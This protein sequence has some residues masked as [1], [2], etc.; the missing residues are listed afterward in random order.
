VIAQ[1]VL[2]LGY[3]LDNWDTIPGMFRP[4]LG[5]TQPPIQCIP[6]A[7]TPGVKLPGHAADHSPPSGAKVKN[8]WSCTS[9]PSIC[10]HGVV[11]NCARYTSSCHGV[12]INTG[13]T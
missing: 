2:Q 12:W 10:L 9:S 8:V 3:G 4:V 5:P 7:L 13:K 1:A 11:C 6:G